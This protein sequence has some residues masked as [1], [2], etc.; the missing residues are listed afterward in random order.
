[1]WSFSSL[2]QLPAS[3]VRDRG[4]S[5]SK[6]EKRNGAQ[7]P[8]WEAG[9]S[10]P[11]RQRRGPTPVHSPA[12]SPTRQ[13]ART[14]AISASE[15]SRNINNRDMDVETMGGQDMELSASQASSSAKLPSSRTPRKERIRRRSTGNLCDSFTLGSPQGT[16]NSAHPVRGDVG[17]LS[18]TGGRGGVSSSGTDRYI[19]HR[20]RLNFDMCGQVLNRAIHDENI[21]DS[22]VENGGEPDMSIA[23]AA[24]VAPNK[25]S[26]NRVHLGV[27]TKANDMNSQGKRLMDV[28]EY[29]STSI[30]AVPYDD[31]FTRLREDVV[32]SNHGAATLGGRGGTGRKPTTRHIPDKPSRILDA[33]DLMDDYYLNLLH[34][35][36]NNVI[37]VALNQSVYLWHAESGKIDNLM[38]LEQSDDY[39]TSVQWGEGNNLAVGLSGGVVEMWD[40]STLQKTRDMTGHTSRVSSLSWNTTHNPHMLSSGARDSTILHHDIRAARNVTDTLI[41][42][43]QE[44]CGLSWSPDGQTL[45]SG[46]NENRLCIWDLAISNQ[47]RRSG[48]STALSS[49]RSSTPRFTIEEHN[50]AVKAVS[51]CPWQRNVL[52]SGGGTADRTIRIW[53]SSTGSCL[54]SV[55]TGSQVCAIQWSLTEKEFVS[56]H[57]FSDNQLIL[58]RYS[59][60]KLTKLQEFHGHTSRVL[61]LARSPDGHSICS[62]SA[63]ET[64]RFWDMFGNSTPSYGGSSRG[65][66]AGGKSPGA[67]GK[68]GSGGTGSD[69]LGGRSTFLYSGARGGLEMR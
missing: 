23:A 1:M 8:N 42:H 45:A 56:S 44:I 26:R 9:G 22:V 53:N 57:G 47:R 51:W 12:Q 2:F 40:S 64:I 60:S 14:N 29:K 63:D 35:G 28:F 52:A 32:E 38:T 31:G 59:A 13:R 34:W 4:R 65:S 41:G 33:P 17:S 68:A 48:S 61:H 10:S 69:A 15:A 19:P 16:P 5:T 66:G 21:N 24:A 46:G 49:S 18:P 67:K 62:A 6:G 7:D 54:K 25:H 27:L 43:T 3:P 39:V 37:A 50:A 58:W 55:D 11:S 36:S 20:A 30:G